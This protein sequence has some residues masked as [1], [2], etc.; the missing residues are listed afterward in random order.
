M[1]EA[2]MIERAEATAWSARL[3]AW[4]LAHVSEPAEA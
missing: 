2:G 4:K 3:R 1:V